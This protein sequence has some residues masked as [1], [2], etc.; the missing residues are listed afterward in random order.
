VPLSASVSGCGVRCV[1]VDVV[2]TAVIARPREVV[3]GFA[4]DPDNATTWY[5]NIREV[6]W[7]TPPPLQVGSRL[8]FVAQFLGRRLAYTYEVV[9]H[10][11]GERFVMRTAQGPFPMETTY[12]W[13]DVPGGTLMTLRNAGEPSGFARVSAPMMA[14]AMRRANTKDLALLKAILEA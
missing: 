2:T 4:A 8:S 11:P 12:S 9:E 7:E 1:A 13:A 3:A 14:A 5:A 6:S 10:A